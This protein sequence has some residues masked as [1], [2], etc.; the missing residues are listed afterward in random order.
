MKKPLIQFIEIAQR[1][2]KATNF[3]SIKK[4]CYNK[5]GDFVN[6]GKKIFFKSIPPYSWKMLPPK[7]KSNPNY[8]K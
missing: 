4:L 5:G 7:A 6:F 1:N 3:E 8:G 2:G